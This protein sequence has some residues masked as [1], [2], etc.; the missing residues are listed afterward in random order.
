MKYDTDFAAVLS[1][2]DLLLQGVTGTLEISAVSLALAIPFGL[3]LAL[4]RSS[5]HK[6]ISAAATA[7]IE[8]LRS[9]SLFVLIF[10]FFYAFP[11]LINLN[12]D[13]FAAGSIAIA[14]HFSA[15]FAEVFR[16]GITSI[17]KTQW[18]GAK[19]LGLS[20]WTTLRSVILPQALLR[21]SPVFLAQSI[22]LVKATSFASVIAFS[23]LSFNAARIASDTFRPIET[24]LVIAA[25]YFVP[26]FVVRECALTRNIWP[27]R[28]DWGAEH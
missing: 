11:I 4:M 2:G 15:L 16:A 5:S 12:L 28:W 13:A 23:E 26:I 9:S 25:I 19:A 17:D 10:W 22:E 1:H 21:I 24:F 6:V 20:R 3:L 14:A 27:S 7:Y 8:L 18:D